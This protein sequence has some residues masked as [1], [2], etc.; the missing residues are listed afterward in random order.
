MIFRRNPLYASFVI[1]LLLALSGLIAYFSI[2]NIYKEFSN[3]KPNLSLVLL[4]LLGMYGVFILLTLIVSYFK[5]TPTIVLNKS[6]ILFENGDEIPLSN[7]SNIIY[8]GDKNAG[9]FLMG[10]GMQIEFIDKTKKVLLDDLYTDLWKLKQSL[11][12]SFT[13]KQEPQEFTIEPILEEDYQNENK[14]AF[15]GFVFFSMMGVLSYLFGFMYLFVTVSAFFKERNIIWIVI[16]F[17]IFI[18]GVTSYGLHYFILTDNHLIIKNHNFFW[19]NDVFRLS[20]I[21][22][23]SFEKRG[24]GFNF[25]RIIT[26]DFKMNVYSADTLGQKQW[27]N[28]KEHLE[29]KDIEVNN[30]LHFF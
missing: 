13:L 16:I 1:I 21:K 30:Y 18:V 4:C 3:I 12:Q 7:I 11:Y 17:G 9:F 26:N 28:L 10:E 15:K 5:K 24:K 29:V 23:I 6:S 20:D 2:L 27:K 22:K 8:T 14:T 25:M 19:K